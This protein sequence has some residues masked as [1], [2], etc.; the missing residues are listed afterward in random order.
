MKEF[1]ERAE[2]L[3]NDTIQMITQDNEHNTTDINLIQQSLERDDNAS[4]SNTNEKPEPQGGIPGVKKPP[5]SN[6][7]PAAIPKLKPEMGKLQKPTTVK[8]SGIVKPIQIVPM[9]ANPKTTLPK[10]AGPKPGGIQKTK[11]AIL[12][13]M[14]KKPMRSKP[15]NDY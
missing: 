5:V 15:N 2:R 10:P 3:A 4:S 14:S 11:P 12:K 9:I 1:A 8:P 13:P 7:L 6:P